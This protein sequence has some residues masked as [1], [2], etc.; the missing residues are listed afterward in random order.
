M[1]WAACPRGHLHWGRQGAAGLLLAREGLALLQLRARWTHQGGTWSIPGGAREPGETAVQAALREADE[2]LGVPAG[3]IDIHGEHRATCGSWSYR[4][5][6]AHP[7]ATLELRDRGESDDHR[8]VT[9][10]EVDAL[11]LHPGFARAWRD[12]VSGL[13]DFVVGSGQ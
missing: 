12:P 5:I 9:P 11:T 7:T 8:W 3:V 6:F 13:R 10:D 4:T 1:N 2:E